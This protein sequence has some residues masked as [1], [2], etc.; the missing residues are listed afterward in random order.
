MPPLTYTY[1]LLLADARRA[2]GAGVA[3]SASIFTPPTT[4]TA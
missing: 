3:V 2:G 4:Y 1:P